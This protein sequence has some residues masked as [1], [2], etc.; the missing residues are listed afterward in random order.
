MRFR[1]TT[2]DFQGNNI[3]WLPEQAVECKRVDAPRLTPSMRAAYKDLGL[4]Q[5]LVIYPGPH[6]YALYENIRVIPLVSLTESPV[7]L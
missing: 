2:A 4:A 3:L 5:L 1:H 6:P 7:N